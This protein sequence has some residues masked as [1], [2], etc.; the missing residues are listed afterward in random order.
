MTSC[1]RRMTHPILELLASNSRYRRYLSNYFSRK[2]RWHKLAARFNEMFPDLSIQGRSDWEIAA[3]IEIAE[4]TIKMDVQVIY[5]VGANEGVWSLGFANA[6]RGMEVHSFEPISETYR[7]LV[8][9]MANCPSVTTHNL[10]FGRSRS[11]MRM[12]LDEFDPASSILKMTNR[13]LVEYPQT[14]VSQEVE[15]VVESMDEYVRKNHLPTPDLVKID[16]QGYEDEVIAGGKRVLSDARYVWIELNLVPLYESGSIFHSTYSALSD[17]GFRL[18]DI[19]YLDR[20]AIDRSLLQLD[21]IFM[22]SRPSLG[23]ENSH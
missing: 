12:Y 22:N 7:K 3:L 23:D 4:W 18:H 20:S 13:H 14:G 16:V 2:E 8:G 10:A 17:L 21:A 1:I 15:V 19:T 11:T 5:D 9:R 6:R